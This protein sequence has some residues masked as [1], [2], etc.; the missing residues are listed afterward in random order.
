MTVEW[1]LEELHCPSTDVCAWCGD[2]ECDGIGCIAALNP[3]H[4]PD[5]DA[6]EELHSLLRAGRVYRQAERYLAGQDNR[7]Y[8]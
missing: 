3:E 8:P 5:H 4:E 6:I 2:S 1:P 7:R